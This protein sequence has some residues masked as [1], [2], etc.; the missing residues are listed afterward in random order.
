L[1]TCRRPAAIPV[2]G[3]DVTPEAMAELLRVDIEDWKAEV[4]SIAEHF[5]GYGDKVP[6]A[7][8]DD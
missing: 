2:D 1:A 7:L 3:V 5:A 6:Q 8:R 4:P